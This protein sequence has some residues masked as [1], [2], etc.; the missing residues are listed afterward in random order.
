MQYYDCLSQELRETVSFKLKNA[1]TQICCL[2][3]ANKLVFGDKKGGLTF[4]DPS[5]RH[6]AEILQTGSVTKLSSCFA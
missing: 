5:H 3:K 1:I 4:Y 2:Q 6:F